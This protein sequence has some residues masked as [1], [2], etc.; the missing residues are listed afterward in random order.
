[1]AIVH[2]YSRT[3]IGESVEI[4]RIEIPRIVETTVEI[5][6]IEIP[7]IVETTLLTAHFCGNHL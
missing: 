4:P 3:R 7:R 6:R 5:P 1:M 2:V